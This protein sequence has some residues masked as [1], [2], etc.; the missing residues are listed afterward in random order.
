MTWPFD[1]QVQKLPG[2]NKETRWRVRGMR[3][4][5]YGKYIIQEMQWECLT[6]SGKESGAK[7]ITVQNLP[8]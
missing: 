2:G 1:R 7:W 3:S 4:K 6:K 5:M 8:L